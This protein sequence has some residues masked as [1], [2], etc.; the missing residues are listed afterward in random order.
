MPVAQW[1]D[2]VIG[3]GLTGACVAR[4]LADAGRQVLMVERGQPVSEPAGSHLRN[5]SDYRK[6]PDGWFGTVDRYVTYLDSDADDPAL[7]G[8]YTS[9]I[10]GGS[11][12][13]W[14]NNCPRATAGLDQPDHLQE[15]EWEEAYRQAEIYLDV[16]REEFADSRRASVIRA[17]LQDTLSE[18]GRSLCHLPLAGRRLGPE[19]IHYSAPADVLAAG[20]RRGT[21]LDGSAER[22]EL[23]GNQVSGVWVGETLHTTHH[24]VLATGAVDAPLMLW[25]SGIA[26]PALGRHLS[27]HPVLATQVVLDEG[28]IAVSEN[29]PLPRLG[30]PA[31]PS[32][33]W[34]VMVLRDTNPLPVDPSDLAVPPHR[35]VEIQAFGPI[36]PHPDNRMWLDGS[37][38]VHFDVP[39]RPTDQERLNAIESDVMGLVQGLG[40]LRRGCEPRWS[41]PGTAHLMGSCRMGAED[42]TSVTNQ[43]GTLHG[44]EGVDIAGNAVIPTRLL[45]NP[46]LTSLA[47]AIHGQRARLS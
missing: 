20:S 34:F 2:I 32:H 36:D 27:F 9:S 35:L 22:L 39:I 15:R 33:P 37:G 42:G 14:T 31:T 21:R 45:V 25:R 46:T 23:N 3:S 24:V 1:D 30:I 40:R 5:R 47:L 12:I 18:Q 28:S 8:A 38:A 41:P 17:A 43:N 7:P 26:N 11:G 19:T 13:L 44:F 6:D 29:D 16:R 10:V 4:T